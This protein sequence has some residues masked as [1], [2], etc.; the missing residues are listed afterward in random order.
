[1][2]FKSSLDGNLN[3]VEPEKRIHKRRDR[4]IAEATQNLIN[5]K[6]TLNDFLQQ[7]SHSE[8]NIIRLDELIVNPIDDSDTEDNIDD[9]RGNISETQNNFLCEI[10][11]KNQRNIILIPC[12]H[13]K[14]CA[15]CF[16]MHNDLAI[17]K[18]NSNVLCPFCRQIVQ[19]SSPVFV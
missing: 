8:N 1:M 5:K 7:M 6:I 18:G 16:K 10:C 15:D 19:N 3:S 13:F 4:K 12:N 17:Q 14:L 9:E 2:E 11:Y